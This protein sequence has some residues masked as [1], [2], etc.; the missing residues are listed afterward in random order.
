MAGTI[1]S[2]GIGSGLD[3][4]GIIDK[5]MAVERQP[6]AKL[7][8]AASVMQTQLS[9]FGQIQSLVSSFKDATTP[10]LSAD[11]YSLTAATSADSAAV[12]A[13]STA[14]AAPGSY[15]VSV[16][17]I[18]SAQTLAS[19]AG[20]FAAATNVVGT[21]T[22]TIRLGSWDAGATA[23]TPK[24][25]SSDVAITIDSSKNTLEGI[26]DAINAAGAGV[27]ASIV[28]DASGVRLALQSSST[29]AD[30][31]FRITVA[32][33]DGNATDAL[34]LSRI[35]YDPPGGATQ[36]TRTAAAANTQA[37]INGIAVTSSDTKI[38]AIDGLTLTANR[39]T[40]S[41][42][43]VSVTRNTGALKTLING[44]ASAY[45]ALNTFIGETTKYD[46]E[47]K[48]AALLQ[49][50]R[51][52]IGLQSQL[53][54]ILGGAGA[55]S[56]VFATLSQVGLEFQRDGSLKVNDTKLDAA[57][58][59]PAELKKALASA[60]A[61]QP[62]AYGF[63]KKIA[64]WADAMLSTDGAL[65]SRTASIQKRISANQKDQVRFEERMAQVEARLRKQYNALDTTM[66]NANAL[67]RY[68]TQQITTWNNIKTQA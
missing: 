54:Q 57:M 1:S 15:S 28:T 59:N 5:L 61:A 29:G 18:A 17:A 33:D 6:I 47:N 68:V 58:A 22:I 31:G 23:F 53:R 7:R 21:G 63:A 36:M 13:T 56:T 40:T 39:V 43:A 65:P 12:G 60:D 35:A 42:V 30:N 2:A 62:S 51:T 26:R 8:S 41:P 9:A 49:G 66:A 11:N 44:F 3:V 27:T 48:Q 64:V 20:Q 4:A 52:A 19:T 55:G 45:N 37:T 16:S 10:L 50:D 67:S 34:G 32:D 24:T 14:K 46:P 38:S 25:G